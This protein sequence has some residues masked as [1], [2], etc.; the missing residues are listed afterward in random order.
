MSSHKSFL[1]VCV[2]MFVLARVNESVL[3]EHI[4]TIQVTELYIFVCVDMLL[5][6][7]S[8]FASCV[9]VAAIVGAAAHFMAVGKG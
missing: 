3:C 4:G 7:P 6:L 9:A 8:D 1:A 2:C 5:W